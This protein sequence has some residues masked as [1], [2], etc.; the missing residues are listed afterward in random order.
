MYVPA[1]SPGILLYP[2]TPCL[3][4]QRFLS[5]SACVKIKVTAPSTVPAKRAKKFTEDEVMY[6]HEYAN[7][8][9]L[10][11]HTFG[12]VTCINIVIRANLVSLNLVLLNYFVV[13][14]HANLKGQ[15]FAVFLL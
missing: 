12:L 2:A 5:P 11:C 10:L 1:S 14:M 3:V 9:Y 8:G 15:R 13:T 6:V 7:V 4:T